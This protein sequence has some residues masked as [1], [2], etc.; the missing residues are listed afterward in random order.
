MNLSYSHLG[1]KDYDSVL[2]GI[3]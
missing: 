3:G 2:I 1:N